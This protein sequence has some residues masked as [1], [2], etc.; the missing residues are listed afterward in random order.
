MNFWT[1]FPDQ[2][3]R[4]SVEFCVA[5]FPVSAEKFHEYMPRD[6]GLVGDD[7]NRIYLEGSQLPEG[8]KIVFTDKAVNC[9]MVVRS[10]ANI[11]NSRISFKADGQFSYVGTDA[12]LNGVTAILLGI[13]DFVLVGNGV[14][15]TASSSWSTGFNSGVT[16]NGLIVGD[17]C[18]IGPELVIRPADG[19][20][21][22]DLESR[23]QL[24]KSVRPV[25]IEPYVWIAQRSAILKS[26][27]VGAC[28]IIAYGA[29]VTKSCDQFSLLAGVP[30]KAIDLGRKMW[31]R[32]NAKKSVQIQKFYERRFLKDCSGGE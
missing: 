1:Y 11:K 30:A 19:H 4:D 7:S 8:L 13:R 3:T 24:N 28:S 20:L 18:L 17:H 14:S 23:D 12:V 22:I 32:N 10:G 2:Y 25:V 15:V 16:G 27:R 21:V 29:V 31:L 5:D 9:C 26:V 6:I